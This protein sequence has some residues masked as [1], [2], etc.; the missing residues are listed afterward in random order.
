MKPPEAVL[1]K[2]RHVASRLPKR[3]WMSAGVI[4]FAFACTVLLMSSHA[5]TPTANYEVEAG[6]R[7]GNAGLASDSG[8]SGGTA[9]KFGGSATGSD[10][11]NLPLDPWWTGGNNF[12]KQFPAADAY[13]WSDPSFF[14]V[15][16]FATNG[17]HADEV[18]NMNNL[19]INTIIT[20][21]YDHTALKANHISVISEDYAP[22]ATATDVVA[23]YLDDEGDG[24]YDNGYGDMNISGS[25]ANE[26]FSCATS[27]GCGFTETVYLNSKKRSGSTNVLSP[28]TNALTNGGG[29][30]RYNGYTGG[31][32]GGE[33]KYA[34]FI[35][36]NLPATQRINSTTSVSVDSSYVGKK[37]QDIIGAD[38]YW[39]EFSN[40]LCPGSIYKT[41]GYEPDILNCP[42]AS[43]YGRNV[44]NMR[45]MDSLDGAYQPLASDVE[46]GCNESG[47]TPCISL[48]GIGGAM[49]SSTI[50][51]G[52]M[53]FY[54]PNYGYQCNGSTWS[55]GYNPVRYCNATTTMGSLLKNLN[56]QFRTLAPVLNSP[57]LM[58]NSY[59]DTDDG[60]AAT[61]DR[62]NYSSAGYTESKFNKNLDTMLKWYD[63][64]YYLFSMI[65]VNANPGSYQFTLPAG[66]NA[67]SVQVLYDNDDM[68]G[69][70]S[71]RT[72][73]V[74]GGAFTDSF[75]HEY[76]S[77]IYKIT[78]T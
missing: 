26:S 66:L 39:Y 68:P 48:G 15:V 61:I 65:N 58:Y 28:F 46:L 13:G 71:S 34:P 57:T 20:G 19:G 70:A 62:S 33:T 55:G 36:D 11:L 50:H 22:P 47:G 3:S 24:K 75:A 16:A 69:T 9:V 74:N 10:P 31:I 78:P 7:S 37:F 8:A 64:S 18:A 4:L 53:A 21:A 27:T 63:G 42:R 35:N 14:P 6:T 1:R 29:R 54:F 77:H 17:D 49:W 51:G 30:M 23:Y 73:P 52:M 40:I 43:A 5:A 76:T 60:N 44:D 67:S 45:R 2:F 32:I 56:T 41:A 72:I 25:G 38:R 12:Y 59:Q